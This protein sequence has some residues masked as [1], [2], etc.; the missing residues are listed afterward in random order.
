MFSTPG[1]EGIY[2]SAHN[3]CRL[4]GHRLP[5]TGSGP[6]IGLCR[7]GVAEILSGKIVKNGDGAKASSRL[8]FGKPIEAI[9]IPQCGMEYKTV[10]NP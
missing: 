2:Q 9:V 6:A 5:P 1:V 7:A 8:P 3:D 10:E 4:D